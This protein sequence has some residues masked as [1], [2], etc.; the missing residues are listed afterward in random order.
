M[1]VFSAVAI[2]AP[3]I[4]WIGLKEWAVFTKREHYVT[5]IPH[6]GLHKC[7]KAIFLKDKLDI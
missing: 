1:A 5:T 7:Y 2:C 3:K 6:Y 4:T